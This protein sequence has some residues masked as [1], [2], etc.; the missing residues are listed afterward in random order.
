MHCTAHCIRTCTS[1]AFDIGFGY[2]C[3]SPV[4][5]HAPSGEGACPFAI[6]ASVGQLIQLPP[7]RI[8]LG[9]LGHRG[10]LNRSRSLNSGCITC[11][12]CSRHACGRASLGSLAAWLCTAAQ[13]G[14]HTAGC[15][16]SR[17]RSVCNG[18]A[19]ALDSRSWRTCSCQCAAS[20]QGGPVPVQAT[21]GCSLHAPRCINNLRCPARCCH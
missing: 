11:L 15:S 12:H 16:R 13:R 20:Q 1:R 19:G 6:C 2:M 7:G 8:L 21:A 4:F 17:V 3:F 14:Q 5:V 9:L 18:G 10:L